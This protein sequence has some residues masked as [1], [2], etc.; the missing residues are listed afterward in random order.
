[1]ADFKKMYQGKKMTPAQAIQ[2]IKNGDRIALQAGSQT[3]VVLLNELYRQKDNFE[4][5]TVCGSLSIRDHDVF[6]SDCNDRIKYMST[7]LGAYERAAMKKGRIIDYYCFQLKDAAELIR[8]RFQPNVL[9]VMARP[10]DENGY[11]NLSMNPGEMAALAEGVRE[12]V[13]QINDQ[14][15]H[16]EGSQMHISQVTALF[17]EAEEVAQLVEAPPHE[18]DEKVA[19][20]IV[21]RIPNAACLQIG[22]GGIPNAV[23]RSLVNHKHLGIHTEM[24]TESMF[25]LTQK[26]AVD[27]SAKQIDPGIAVM[28]F[29]MGSKEMYQFLDHNPKTVTR[30]IAY[31]NDPYVVAQL[32]NFVSVNGCISVD[33]TGQVCS[34]SI[35]NKQFSGTG[36]Q[37]DFVRGA[38]MSKGGMSF[39]AM[40]STNTKKDGT[41]SSKIIFNHTSGTVVTTTRT[42][43][44]YLVTEYGVADLKNESAFQRVKKLI[45]IAHPDFRDELKFE[46]KKAGLL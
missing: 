34:E 44:Q 29:T 32:D 27:N 3:S 10:M 35:G 40:R 36:G 8:T 45:D 12:V 21:E 28:G 11:L 2:R 22:I 6:K 16:I 38:Q 18:L 31:T 19:A 37:L 42:D 33:L 30:P 26:G 24:Y 15:P 9:F 23:G 4:E 5:V 43:V 1:M 13:V 39:I 17:E 7:F 20:Y 46:A 14:L 25:Y 41:V